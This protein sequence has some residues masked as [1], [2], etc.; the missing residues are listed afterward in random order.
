MKLRFLGWALMAAVLLV[1]GTSWA[2]DALGA[3]RTRLE[4]SVNPRSIPADGQ[5]STT[6]TVR[7]LT[8]DGTP[9]V[10]DTIEVL[11]Q[12]AGVFD[13]FRAL[14]DERGEAVFVFTSARGNKYRP[15]APVPVL[16]I[17]TSLGSLIE[18]N[19]TVTT[20]INVTEVKN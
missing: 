13:R 1:F 4:T 12:G 6:L 20:I 7:S 9:R 5:S 2:V 15:A 8:P 11:N 18:V 10:R 16:V 19:K 17:N 3:S 14:T